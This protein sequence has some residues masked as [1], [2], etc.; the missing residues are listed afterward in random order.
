MVLC[1]LA[2]LLSL[3]F[4]SPAHAD[5]L[6]VYTLYSA[7][8]SMKEDG[9]IKG[10]TVDLAREALKRMGHEAN[11]HLLPWA[12]SLDMVRH[13]DG[14]IL[15]NAARKTEREEWFH[16]STEPLYTTDLVILKRTDTPLV[17]SPGQ[18]DFSQYTIGIARG[19]AFGPGYDRFL[20]SA[21]FKKIDLVPSNLWTLRTLP[22]GRIDIAPINQI[23]AQYYI[24]Q[25]NLEGVL[26]FAMDETGN[27][28]VIDSSDAFAAFS[29]ISSSQAMTDE[30]TRTLKAMKEDGTYQRIWDTYLNK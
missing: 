4:I 16:Y 1:S 5:T 10:I 11:I 15:L 19:F 25:N 17:I 3:A 9:M 12:R 7:P 13:G 18:T 30:F 8:Y 29:K 23:I 2:L 14:H 27:P 26:E 22:A 24:N 6:Q 20:E 21:Q 28:F